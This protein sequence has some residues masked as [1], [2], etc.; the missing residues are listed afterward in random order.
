MGGCEWLGEPIN[1]RESGAQGCLDL[2]KFQSLVV[3]GRLDFMA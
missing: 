3:S 1:N 2:G